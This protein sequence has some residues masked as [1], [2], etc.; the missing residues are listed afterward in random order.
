MVQ[1]LPPETNVGSQIGQSLGMGMQ[2]GLQNALQQQYQRGILQQSLAG[3]ENLDTSKM[4]QPQLVAA[5]SKA[6][7]GVPGG[8]IALSKLLPIALQMQQAKLTP[9]LA[10]IKNSDINSSLFNQQ[11]SSQLPGFLSGTKFDQP[12]QQAQPNTSGQQVTIQQSQPS[13]AF[14]EAKGIQLGT[15]LPYNL[16]DQISPE[17]RAL[18]LDQ[19]RRAGGDVAFTGQQIDNYNAGKINQIDLANANVDKQ[20]AQVQRQF[21]MEDQVKRKLDE[22]LPE[23]ISPARRNLYYNLVSKELPESKDFTS[24]FQKISKKIVDFEKLEKKFIGSIP[25]SGMYG[26]T[27]SQEKSLRQS[28]KPLIK[29]DPLAYNILEEAMTKDVNGNPRNSIVDVAKTLKPL[30]PQVSNIISKSGDYRQLI[31]PKY[32][33]SDQAIQNNIKMAQKDQEREI[34]R[35][36]DQLSKI[37]NEDISLIN[38]YTDLSI[39]GWFPEQIKDLFD[40]LSDKFSSQQQTERAQLNEHPR[41]PARYI[42]ESP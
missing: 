32:N 15:Y 23:D 27:K 1:I 33:I 20:A 17:Q 30:T 28:A 34:P 37:W 11:Q 31:Y 26:F 24:A 6:L 41:I 21:Q 39:K 5:Y 13:S 8:D 9:S 19:V 7:L 3:L 40:E 35:L 16:G 38:L 29:Q 10:D 14:P 25:D 2:S 4:S 22:Q 12:N 36:N 42:L 18:V